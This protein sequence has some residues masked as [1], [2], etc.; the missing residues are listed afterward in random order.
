MPAVPAPGNHD[1]IRS[2]LKRVFAAPDLW[3]AHFA[4]PANRPADLPELAGQSYYLDYQGVRIVAL[5]VN[6]F[7]N[8]DYRESQ[9]S[10][11]QAALLKWLRHVLATNPQRWT[12]VVQH[13][14]MYSVV[15]G[16][17]Y[18]G[19]RAALGT[20]YDEFQVD[21]VLQ[22][23]DHAYGRTHKVRDGRLVDPQS[24]GTV[25]AVSVSG[26]K[27]YPVGSRWTSLMAR[28]HGGAQL[29]QVVSVA[30]D[31]LSYESREA[32]GTAVDAFDV[33][34]TAGAASRYVNRAPGADRGPT[35]AGSAR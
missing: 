20:L 6:A 9:R 8:E 35:A 7:A 28:L 18:T 29:Y 5:D 16:R 14:P 30:G 27:M 26:T 24:P 25:Y 34:K 4:L 19:M 2:T 15:K 17:D 11:V 12:V 23:H 31:R 1:V 13:Y 21:L 3:S 32:D 33:I 22:G 10:R